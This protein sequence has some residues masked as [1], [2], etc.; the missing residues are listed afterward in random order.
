MR[1]LRVGDRGKALARERG[2]V[3]IVYEY[4]TVRLQE[5]GVDVSNVL[6]G[7]CEETGQVLI[8]PAQSTPK[9]KEARAATKVETCQVRLPRQLHDIL[10]LLADH[11]R[12]EG[13]KFWPALVRFYLA[14]AVRQ[15]RLAARIARLSKTA[16][17]SEGPKSRFT[18][19]CE[20]SLLLEVDK[21]AK[22]FSGVTRSDLIRG[23]IVA[24]KDD[25]LGKR[26][27]TRAKKLEAIAC[28]V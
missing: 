22:E 6:V 15:R 24:A 27:R 19:R 3:P 17:A 11:Y 25:V 1:I 7:V 12:A 26:S 21:L 16:L 2:L 10:W 4:R 13:S 5:S 23:A 8:I 9:L 20:R 18:V 28:A 14:E